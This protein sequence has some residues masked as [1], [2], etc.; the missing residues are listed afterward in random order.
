LRGKV[1]DSLTI[2]EGYAHARLAGINL[3]AAA[4]AA[5]GSLDRVEGI[6]KILGFVNTRSHFRNHP[7]VVNGCSDL[8]VEVLGEKGKHTRSAVGV[9]SLPEGI[10]VEIEGIFKVRQ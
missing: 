3:L 9:D 8:L 1:G 7:K 5:L 6:V 2:E 10:S 4:K